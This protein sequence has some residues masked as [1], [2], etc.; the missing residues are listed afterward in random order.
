M[1]ENKRE[2]SQKVSK[3]MLRSPYRRWVGTHELVIME[4]GDV[5]V[6]CKS[7]SIVTVSSIE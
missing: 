1:L 5:M 6:T 7:T 2:E 3:G 4:N